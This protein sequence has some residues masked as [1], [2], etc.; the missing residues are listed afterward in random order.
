M[1]TLKIT[2]I[3]LVALTT[4]QFALSHELAQDN[5]YDKVLGK[6]PT[7]AAV[8]KG[9]LKSN[10]KLRDEVC[11]KVCVWWICTTYYCKG[12]LV[13]CKQGDPKSKCCP[14]ETPVCLPEVNPEIC[15]PKSKPKKCGK[16]C[17]A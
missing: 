2:S 17:C 3:I 8:R 1:T 10:C 5:S 7:S 16:Q 4:I 11:A 15:C 6:V 14:S 12:D 13:C 9:G